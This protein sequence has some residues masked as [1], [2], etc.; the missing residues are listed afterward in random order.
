MSG[1][2][3]PQLT[4]KQ[5]SAVLRRHWGLT[6]ARIVELGSYE[7]QN[8]RVD[9]DGRRFVLK[10]AG[11]SQARTPLELEC[12]VLA[13]LAAAGAPGLAT[14]EIVPTA[15][16]AEIVEADGQRVRLLTWV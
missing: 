12:E 3:T 11:P 8:L 1:T 14:P 7:D 15:D 9:A 5:A 10:V 2:D 13:A 16:D 6:A 4:V